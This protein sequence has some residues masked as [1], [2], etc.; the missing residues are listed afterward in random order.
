MRART[1]LVPPAVVAAIAMSGC[2]TEKAVLTN[3]QGQTTTCQ[4]R[5]HVGLVS[6]I[7]VS[8]K[9]HHCVKQAEANGYK[10]QPPTSS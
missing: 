5:G 3:D 8:M 4:N 10:P 1:I 9:Q 6:P 2:F 7:L